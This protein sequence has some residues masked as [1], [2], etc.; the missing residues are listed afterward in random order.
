MKSTA[1]APKAANPVALL[2]SPTPA[3][4]M[5]SLVV[6]CATS[7]SPRLNAPKLP[8]HVFVAAESSIPAEGTTIPLKFCLDLIFLVI[9]NCAS[10]AFLALS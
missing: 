3:D 4:L 5:N 9:L 10:L 7:A 1:P 8:Y 2:P 6:P